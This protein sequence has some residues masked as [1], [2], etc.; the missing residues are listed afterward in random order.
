VLVYFRFY[1]IAVCLFSFFLLFSEAS[2]SQI[3]ST[4]TNVLPSIQVEEEFL[5]NK[6]KRLDPIVNT[7]IYSGKKTE[8]ISLT[9]SD[10]NIT[11][12]TARQIFAKIPGVF[13]YD[14]EGSNQINIATRG[15]DPHRGWEFNQRKDGVIINSDMY[16]YPASHYSI[17]LESI[18]RIEIVRGAGALQYGAQF[19]GM[20]NYISK[21]G[22]TT[23]PISVESFNTVGSY[24]LLSTYNAIGGKI[25]KLKYYGYVSKRVRNGY[26]E[27]EKTN[28]DAEGI[29][30]TYDPSKQFS[31]RLEWARSNY[32]YK[33]PGPLNDEQF[34]SNPMQATRSRNY[35]NPTINI[36][37]LTLS[38]KPSAST[39]VQYVS[40]AV[41]GQR[42]SVIFDRPATIADTINSSTQQFNN[43]QVDIDSYKSFTQELRLLQ[44]YS[45]GKHTHTFVSGVQIINN[46]LNR[47]QQGKGTTGSDLDFSIEGDWGRNLYF[48]TNNIALFLENSFTVIKNLT[49]NTGARLEL[50][51]STMTGTIIYY[52]SNELPV[53]I[54]RKFPLLGA[55]IN[56]K[57]NAFTELYGGIAQSYRPVLFKDI[58][59]SSIYEVVDEQLKDANGYNAELGARGKHKFLQWDVTGFLLQYN[60]RFG[61]LSFSNTDGEF[62]T[63]RTNIGNSLTK[64]IELFIQANWS[65]KQ[66][67]YISIFTST[68]LMDGRYT[69]GT[70]KKGNEN[71]NI[72]NNKIESVPNII[73]RN[74]LTYYFKKISITCLYSYTSSTFADAFNTVTPNSSGTVGKV[75]GYGILDINA[76]YKVS[77][78]IELK[79]NANNITNEQYFTK[80]P[81]FYPGPGI[82]P[83]D[84]RNVSLSVNLKV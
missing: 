20:I 11:E 39:T 50:G 13:V 47:K 7:Y 42:R 65:L 15:L 8:I 23:K 66:L 64:G 58:V 33:I 83:S 24:N 80:R 75:P 1:R 28:Y 71:V 77:K 63:Y 27:N 2:Y 21:Q 69:S 72:S 10:A 26:R 70:L 41:V 29:T 19:G 57:L 45:L 82:W 38:W 76:S 25:G 43:R 79:V 3:D 14:M 31:I 40:S 68:S 36:P 17:P 32:T 9:N 60:N 34:I 22:D 52:P 4:K 12:K 5:I 16:A 73:T 51:E 49:L 61:M 56:Y 6:L 44:Q 46:N 84:G 55:N 35:F 59:P 74:G 62:Y 18:E 53:T 54:A 81:L 30:F 67:G 48:K 78:M 37:S